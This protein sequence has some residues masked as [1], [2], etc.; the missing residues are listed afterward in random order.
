MWRKMDDA[1]YDWLA[2]STGF[3]CSCGEQS[4]VLI[5]DGDSVKCVCGKKYRL[6]AYLEVWEE[7]DEQGV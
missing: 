5:K 3:T 1:E 2:S 4:F 7:E 6:V